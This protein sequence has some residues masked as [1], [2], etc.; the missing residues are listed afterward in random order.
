MEWISIKDRMPDE[1]LSIYV[2]H[3]GIIDTKIYH[4]GVF[5]SGEIHRSIP[6]GKVE[7]VTHWM[8]VP[9]PAARSDES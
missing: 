3:N 5:Y 1:N 7:N 9:F 2:Y 8:Y 4:R 6:L